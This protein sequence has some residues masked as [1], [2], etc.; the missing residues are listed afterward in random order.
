MGLAPQGHGA[1]QNHPLPVGL[2]QVLGHLTH[3]APSGLLL[4][5]AMALSFVQL[6]LS[7][8]ERKGKLRS[9]DNT[10]EPETNTG[11]QTLALRGSRRG[12]KKRADQTGSS[13]TSK[14]SGL[15]SSPPS[16]PLVCKCISCPAPSPRYVVPPVHSPGPSGSIPASSPVCDRGSPYSIPPAHPASFHLSLPGVTRGIA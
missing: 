13:W 3:T 14:V 16:S 10:G 12:V 8:G 4:S 9:Q 11:H 15:L 5:D 2:C 1:G 7:F 6:S